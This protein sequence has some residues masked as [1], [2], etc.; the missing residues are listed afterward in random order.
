[1]RT[2]PASGCQDLF[3]FNSEILAEIWL[4]G[5]EWFLGIG[6][7]TLLN[8]TSISSSIMVED[9]PEV[10]SDTIKTALINENMED[11]TG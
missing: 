10:D 9:L 5:S 3:L 1:L 2:N 7:Q 4:T 6:G 8:C 11:K